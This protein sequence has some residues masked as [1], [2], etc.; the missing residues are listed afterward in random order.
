MQ[1]IK[2]STLSLLKQTYDLKG[3]RFVVSAFSFFQ[4]GKHNTLLE[5]NA[6][7]TRLK[8]YL[9]AGLLLDTG[10]AK[11]YAECLLAGNAYALGGQ[12]VEQMSIELKIG[13]IHKAVQVIGDRTCTQNLRSVSS[14]QPFV[15]MPLGDQQSYG[16]VG[17]KENSKGK[18]VLDKANVDSQANIYHLANLY[19]ADDDITPDKK[20]RRVAS[21]LPRDF[22]HPQRAQYQGTY[23][24]E[25]LDHVHPGF[26]SDT[27]SRL[28]NVAAP[29]QQQPQTFFPGESYSLSGMHPQ[30]PQLKS[31]LPDQFVRAF[32]TQECDGED[33]FKEI[34]THIDTV[35]FFPDLELGIA[36]HRGS[37][38][39]TDSAGLDIKNLLL[40]LE[41][42]TDT[43]RDKAYFQQVLAE[44][45]NPKTAAG[46]AFHASQL[47]PQQSEEETARRAKLYAQA[48]ADY[49]QKQAAQRLKQLEKM[50][51][52]H[53]ELDWDKVFAREQAQTPASDAPGPIPQEFIDKRDFDLTPYIKW[54]RQQAQN[55]KAKMAESREELE[56]HSKKEPLRPVD[57]E[58]QSHILARFAEVVPV[59]NAD[60]SA[61]DS[62]PSNA[63]IEQKQAHMQR[64]ML[65]SQRRTRQL[66]PGVMPKQQVSADGAALLR[67]QVIACMEK[68]ESLAGRDL[69]GADLSGLDLSGQDLRNVM[70]EKANLTDANLTGCLCDGVVL[71][72][73]QLERVR[74]DRCRFIRANLSRINSTSVSCTGAVFDHAVIIESHFENS[75]FVGTHFSQLSIV[76]SDFSGC[77][78]SKSEWISVRL[79]QQ[80][81]TDTQWQNAQLTLCTLLECRLTASQWVQ[82]SLTRCAL[83][84]TTLAQAQFPKV[85]AQRVQIDVTD[86]CE[87]VGFDNGH[88]EY[89]SFRNLHFVGCWFSAS[90]F[91]SCDFTRAHLEECD[92]QHS[93]WHSSL[94]FQGN[95]TNS[96]LAS[97]LF[98][99]SNLRKT[100]F[101][102]SDLTAVTFHQTN[103]RETDFKHCVMR[104]VQRY[105]LASL[106]G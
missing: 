54:A 17:F 83:L 60:K 75:C 102:D 74:L 100:G 14:P 4:L 44:R 79:I 52:E 29:E 67:Q 65:K 36:V 34:P 61:E 68:G 101:V 69:F 39:V 53:P 56:K 81:L 64:M 46:H 62:L 51:S 11:G 94:I 89:C 37:L 20:I 92:L 26:P 9:A 31:R 49:E 105:P 6:Q 45:T 70:L 95:I 90:A 55:A 71:T 22:S 72:E 42:I 84:K 12:A 50:R 33:L 58:S 78:F 66:S 82:A 19:L 21:F 40:A 99:Q 38:P 25:W 35:W 48:Q 97:A 73:A 106:K 88:W 104:R 47:L 59:H 96:Q 5:E 1:V 76:T 93:L 57:M 16:G 87:N 7:W 103:L 13:K 2:P 3:H 23:N 80:G 91:Q 43:P 27:D 98:Y 15:R 30:H 10:H 28:F 32:V 63:T 85:K 86:R 24:Q 8:P 77:D 41:N 18:G